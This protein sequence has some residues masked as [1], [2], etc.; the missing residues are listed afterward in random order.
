MAIFFL[1]ACFLDHIL[2]HLQVSNPT[3]FNGIPHVELRARASAGIIGITPLQATR[4]TPADD[5][6]HS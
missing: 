6:V 1:K 5:P 3:N 4:F 2:F